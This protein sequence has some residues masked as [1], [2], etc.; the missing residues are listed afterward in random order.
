M[1]AHLLG[2]PGFRKHLMGRAKE[3]QAPEKLADNASKA[4]IEA[5]E[6]KVDAYEDLMDGWLQK[7]AAITNILIASW[8]EE[9]HQRLIGV[10][11]ASALWNTLCERFENQGVLAKTD[12]L[13]DLTETRCTSEDPE[14]A[15]KTIERLIKK[16]NEYIL[17]GGTLTDDVYAA[18]LTKAMPKKQRPVVQTAI[19]TAMA[20]GKDLD[21]A[22]IHRTLEQSIKFEMADE[23]REH[24]EAM[25]M[26]AKYQRQQQPKAKGSCTNCGY[27]NHTADKCYRPG[28]GAEGQGPKWRKGGDSGGKKGKG[29]AAAAQGSAT[30]KTEHAAEDHAYLTVAQLIYSGLCKISRGVPADLIQNLWAGP[31]QP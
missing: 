28:G 3:P 17:A 7:Q 29:E 14:D 30:G 9:I 1:T 2:Q 13:M 8:P 6:N 16:R 15:L 5:H 19:T 22:L 10:R 12:L 25:A 24:E 18:I 23:R 21:F 4:E 11:P 27:S 26:A 31:R 20:A